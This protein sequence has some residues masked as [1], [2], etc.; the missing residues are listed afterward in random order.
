MSMMIAQE[1][2]S[3][4]AEFRAADEEMQRAVEAKLT[5]KLEALEQRIV[6]DE[7]IKGRDG[8]AADPEAVARLVGERIEEPLHEFIR[9]QVDTKLA[10]LEERF[11]SVP[12]RLPL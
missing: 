2:P 5:T 11:K 3:A 8:Q 4:R 9:A 1:R 10:V 7:R 12:G 6:S